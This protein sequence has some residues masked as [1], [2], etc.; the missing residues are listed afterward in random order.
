LPLEVED[1]C[2]GSLG[3]NLVETVGLLLGALVAKSAELFLVVSP[4]HVVF[5]PTQGMSLDLLFMRLPF[6]ERCLLPVFV[7]LLFLLVS[8]V[9]LV[10]LFPVDPSTLFLASCFIVILGSLGPLQVGCQLELASESGEFCLHGHNLVF[11]R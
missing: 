5:A 6:L 8:V 10:L 2:Q 4:C 9:L 1:G 11:I 7:S 3:C